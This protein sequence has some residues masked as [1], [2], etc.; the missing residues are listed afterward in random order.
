MVGTTSRARQ[1][2]R[3]RVAQPVALTCKEATGHDREMD[4]TDLRLVIECASLAPSVHNT[5]PWQFTERGDSLEVRAD[6]ERR[7]DF[8]D[9]N[10]RQLHIS[11]GA[12]IEFA[13]LAVRS[14]DRACEVRL[15][16]DPQ[17]P[18]LLAVLRVGDA[19]P[20]ADMD[21]AL[22][23]AMPR[24]YTDR[25]AYSDEPLPPAL[26]ADLRVAAEEAG[27]WV[28]VIQQSD[29]R[30]AL[31][32]ILSD[33]E[34]AEAADPAYA[35][36]LARWT[37]DQPESEGL[38]GDAI[39][40]DWPADRVSD[41]PLRDFSGQG[42]HPRPG[43]EPPRAV[44]RDTLVLIGTSKDEPAA[45]LSTGRALAQVLLRATVANASSQPLGPATDF[46]ET[47]A[48]VR[49]ELHL[50]GQPQFLLRLGYGHDQPRTGRRPAS[51]PAPRS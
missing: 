50:V 8:L 17:D 39:R 31:A 36:E 13:R 47:R 42:S 15:L 34:A 21:R 4:E 5:Q 7:L 24:R 38:S 35:E 28:K 51:D 19:E 22:V 2:R 43:A 14:L 49:R 16:P 1:S 33:A 26:L 27:A 3:S 32:A 29:E 30:I 6:R 12:A 18:D 10:A 41:M 20:A 45:W 25:Q 46:A 48:R 9:P 44:E 37:H 11:C 40:Y 23:E